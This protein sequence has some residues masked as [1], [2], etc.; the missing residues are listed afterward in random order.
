MARDP[1]AVL[2]RLRARSRDA[3]RLGLAE[4]RGAE[5]TAA[6]R[7]SDVDCALAREAAG[8]APAD[9]AAWLPAAR[10]ARETAARRLTRA[11]AASAAARE[12]LAARQVEAEAL[13]VLLAA[14]R[15]AQRKAR[16]AAEQR[17]LDDWRAPAR[18][19]PPG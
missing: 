11:E 7:A 2:A 10:A 19:R 5:A 17:A 4:A 9:Y 13:A 6:A 12:A 15:A 18:L 1:L 8:V 14:R 3:A 16:L